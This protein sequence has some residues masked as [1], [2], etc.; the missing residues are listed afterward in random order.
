GAVITD[1]VPAGLSNVY[2]SCVV[3]IDGVFATATVGNPNSVGTR[4]D[5]ICVT[6]QAAAN[7]PRQVTGNSISQTVNLPAGRS[8][9]IR[10]IGRATGGALNNTASVAPPTGF[11]DPNMSN[12]T[13]A[14]VSTNVQPALMG[15]CSAV[16]LLDANG[17][18]NSPVNWP[19]QQGASVA[20]VSFNRTGIANANQSHTSGT[21]TGL[22]PHPLRIGSAGQDRFTKTSGTT[23]SWTATFSTPIALNQLYLHLNDMNSYDPTVTLT[24]AGGTANR[25]ELSG[26][27]WNAEAST[28]ELIFNQSNGQ[29]TRLFNRNEGTGGAD[30][31]PRG[32][33]VFLSDSNSTVTSITLSS[34]NTTFADFIAIEFGARL[35]C[36]YGDAPAAY[37][38]PRAG[39]LA[40]YMQLG[41][42]IPDVEASASSPRD[43]TGDDVTGIDDE[44]LISTA[45]RLTSGAT[46]FSLSNLTV[47]NNSGHPATLRGWIDGNRNNSIDAGEQVSIAIPTD[48][49]PQIVS[50]NWSALS[51]LQNGQTL[52][53]FT[54]LDDADSL[55]GEI[56]DHVL[57]I[58]NELT[59]IQINQIQL[60]GAAGD[61][62]RYDYSIAVDQGATNLD[63]QSMQQPYEQ[64]SSQQL[65]LEVGSFP[66]GIVSISQQIQGTVPTDRE[67][68]YYTTLSCVG[69]DTATVY[70]TQDFD[71]N[72]LPLSQA[73]NLTNPESEDVTCTLTN[74]A[75]R[76]I[77]EGNV[78]TDNS[79]TTGVAGNAYNGLINSGEI[80][81]AGSTVVLNTC[82]GSPLASTVTT[83]DGQYRFLTSSPLNTL[84]IDQTNLTGYSSVSGGVDT[85]VPD[86]YDYDRGLDRISFSNVNNYST[87]DAPVDYDQ[88]NFG[89]AR[90]NLILTT[91]GQQTTTAGGTVSYP[92]TLRTDAVLDVG[93]L[94]TLSTENPTLGWTTVL[95]RDDNCNGVIDAGEQPLTSAIGQMLPNQEICI[96]QRV[97]APST[98]GAGAQHVGSLSA[99]YTATVQNGDILNGDSNTR[100]DTTLVGSAGL[101]MRKQVRIVASCPSTGADVAAFTDQNTAQN[102]D[103][104]EYEI[105]YT[106]RSTRNLTEVRV[107][108]AVPSS[109]LYKAASCASTPSGASCSVDSQPMVDSSGEISWLMTGVVRP[110]EQGRVRFCVQVPPL[111]EPPI[112]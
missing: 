90:L 6:P 106:N 51:G 34:N 82:S 14:S 41:A 95:Y 8:V 108:D 94:D 16:K 101:D 24:L 39:V 73:S 107:R 29:I 67:R 5:E 47:L 80:G 45:P 62:E 56:E 54:L 60:N 12:N 28:Q 58:G 61:Y 92:H 79:G 13:S 63:S 93:T 100:T 15:A 102:G 32:S 66:A 55:F 33:M 38:N 19:V 50:L 105:I 1:N 77:V 112:R 35:S 72:M 25:T 44:D 59:L 76:F 109:T 26:Y 10:V 64:D 17:V 97:N 49:N 74:R 70:L 46:S 75:K 22:A 96:I 18:N 85:Q 69:D 36:D 9:Q 83:A 53:R 87:A 48:P 2:W 65:T 7:I 89:D 31:N 98:A 81:I 4:T 30:I 11:I 111:A 27:S 99:S 84:C 68:G 110:A 37:G 78:F 103:F 43:Y 88:A 21:A 86:R 3:P 20:T 104:L 23:W 91:D 57:L 40:S 42:T 71:Y 52:L